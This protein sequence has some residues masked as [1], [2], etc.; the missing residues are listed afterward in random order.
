MPC[1]P[2]FNTD[3]ID[4]GQKW[5]EYEKKSNVDDTFSDGC[6]DRMR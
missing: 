5:S 6:V 1:F 4:R 2:I 3:S